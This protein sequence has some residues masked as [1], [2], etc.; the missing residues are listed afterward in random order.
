[1]TLPAAGK[2]ITLLKI[3]YFYAN[4]FVPYIELTLFYN[5]FTIQISKL[6]YFIVPKKTRRL[7]IILKP[8][9][10]EYVISSLIPFSAE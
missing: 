9:R 7:Q 8:S 6:H 3:N 1:M 4:N 2:L 10:F 5:Y